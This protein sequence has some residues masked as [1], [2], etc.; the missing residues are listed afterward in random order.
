MARGVNIVMGAVTVGVGA[1]IAGGTSQA[2]NELPIALHALSVA[3]FMAGWNSLNDIKD[4]EV[5]KV[6]KPNRPLVS[7]A[8]TPE[9]AKKFTISM[10][11]ISAICLG[12]IVWHAENY[13]GN[14]EWMDSVAIW[15]LALFLMVAY[16]FDG[17]P[18]KICL[19]R[20]GL[21]GNL[22]VSGLIAVVI[23]FGAASVGHG[24]D[25][26]PW[27]VAL[28]AMMIGTAREVVKDVED[29]AGDTDRE[30]LPMK[31]G[32]A[33]ARSSAWVLALIGFVAMALP[34]GLELLPKGLVILVLPAMLTLLATKP[35]LAKGEDTKAS[36]LLKRS[37]M[38]GLVGFTATGIYANGIS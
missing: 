20:R 19:K 32:P 9:L 5:D 22:A 1:L 25:P 35:P 33:A 23:V 4:I 36:K 14:S 29:L 2:G 13:I 37:L 21:L 7:G 26:L 34:Y 27:I 17:L 12:L 10:M 16:E 3:T 24:T 30:T 31:I 8:I 38:L 6:N 28:C 15:L 18:S 11:S